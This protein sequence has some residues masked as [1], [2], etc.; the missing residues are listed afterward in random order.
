[1]EQRVEIQPWRSIRAGARSAPTQTLSYAEGRASPCATCA[2]SPCCTHLPIHTFTVSTLAELDHAAYL[3]NFERIRLGIRPDG[4]WSTYYVHPCRF[5]DRTTFGCTV[6]DTDRQPQICRSYN[7]YQC[8]YKRALTADVGGDFLLVDRSRLELLLGLVQV[9]D[10][11]DIVGMPTWDELA[12]AFEGVSDPPVDDSA[13]PPLADPVFDG[14]VASSRSS[15]GLAGRRLRVSETTG[16]LGF[17]DESLASPCT[18]CSAPCCETLS[19]P[20]GAPAN[21]SS[22][23]FLRFCLGFPGVELTLTD[24]GWWL[25]VKTRCRHLA[26]GRCAIYGRPERPLQ[27][28]YFDEWKCTYRHEFGEERPAGSLRIRYEQYDAVLAGLSFDASGAVTSVPPVDQL[29]TLVE[30]AMATT[31]AGAGTLPTPVAGV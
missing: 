9:D 18:G 24:A 22:L 3:L 1:M 20:H 26:D 15:H 27:C 6:H 4:E 16:P 10:Q 5:L 12:A 30:D 29:R 2:T 17:D 31:A 13:E 23:D 8:W 28:R 11:R 14:W 25:T 19:F 21:R 7:P